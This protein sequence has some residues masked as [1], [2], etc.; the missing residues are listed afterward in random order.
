MGNVLFK[1]RGLT[2]KVTFEQRP[3][4]R[5]SFRDAGG[6]VPGRRNSQGKG[7][8]GGTAGGQ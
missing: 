2:E 8:E 4:G 1:D 7:P 6:S 5:G 3:E